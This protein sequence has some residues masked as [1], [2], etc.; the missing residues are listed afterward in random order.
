M[1]I[2]SFS[3]APTFPFVLFRDQE[4]DADGCEPAGVMCVRGAAQCGSCWESQHGHADSSLSTHGSARVDLR[5][6]AALCPQ[7]SPGSGSAPSPRG[8][9]AT[10]AAS[11]PG[12]A[13]L[14]RAAASLVRAAALGSANQTPA[15]PAGVGQSAAIICWKRETLWGKAITK[16]F[17]CRQMLSVCADFSCF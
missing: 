4:F 6:W 5:S 11:S 12:D 15:F 1:I 17:H 2:P 13:P 3:P 9:P 7:E 16:A 10:A 8:E 14:S